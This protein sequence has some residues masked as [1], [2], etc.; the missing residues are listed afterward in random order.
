MNTIVNLIAVIVAIASVLAALGHAGY[1]G[2]LYSA[3]NKRA[4]G[5]PIAQYVRTRWA[6]AGGTAAASLL[7]WLLTMGGPALDVL[8]ILLALGSGAVTT[9][10]LQSTQARYRSGG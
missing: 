2:M 7:A 4:G 6:L 3:A 10:A 8:A 9:K 1:L 5:S